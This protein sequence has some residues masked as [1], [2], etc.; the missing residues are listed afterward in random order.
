MKIS[1]LAEF[2]GIMLGDGNL[3]SQ[4]STGNYQI[5][6]AFNSKNEY[7]YLI[8]VKNLANK[9]FSKNFY[10]KYMKDKNC[11]HLCLSNKVLFYKLKKLCSNK[12]KIPLWIFKNR[13]YLKSCIRGLID[14]DG[15]IFRMSKR[16]YRLIRIEFKNMNEKLLN[17]ARK[18]LLLLGFHPS[19]IICN[20][21]FFISRQE[22]IK[23]Y[24]KEIGFN[25]PKNLK[26]FMQL[27]P[28]SSGQ[29]FLLE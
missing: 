25:N 11:F 7:E 10:I 26:R 16:D 28:S 6:I 29:E 19:K 8:F 14:T 27:A 13:E 20:K 3:Y 21:E 15:S 4:E 12:K 22:E 5:R 17:D 2:V 24:V 18:S 9:L 1:G 23:R